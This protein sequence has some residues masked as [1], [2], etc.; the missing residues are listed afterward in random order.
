MTHLPF[1]FNFRDSLSLTA[2]VTVEYKK[3]KPKKD[4]R[5]HLARLYAPPSYEVVIGMN[6]EPPP[7]HA[8]ADDSDSE[9]SD[10]DIA[11]DYVATNSALA[12]VSFPE[13]E[14]IDN[15]HRQMCSD[16]D[17]NVTSAIITC[18][19]EG[20]QFLGK[21]EMTLTDNQNNDF[22]ELTKLHLCATGNQTDTNSGNGKRFV[23]G[24]SHLDDIEVL[25]SDNSKP[26]LTNTDIEDEKKKI[27]YKNEAL[28][29][30]N[31]HAGKQNGV[32]GRS[33]GHLVKYTRS[34]SGIE[35]IHYMDD[36]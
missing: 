6:E 25:E 26:D 3:R 9:I 4:N 10:V 17:E 20:N 34:P 13:N 16:D 19:I 30:V 11:N 18:D 7:Y 28:Q 21:S 12:S 1:L 36:D 35:S 27:H 24:A 32:R 5:E 2:N 23:K 14:N 15:Q 29:P 33:N 22:L 31:G 8:V